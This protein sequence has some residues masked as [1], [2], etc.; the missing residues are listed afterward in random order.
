MP[1][2][3]IAGRAMLTGELSRIGLKHDWWESWQGVE[4]VASE[5]GQFEFHSLKTSA[6][7]H[8][9]YAKQSPHPLALL[10]I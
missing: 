5:F 9:F 2:L 8:A 10:L 4:I 7:R 3:T 6:A 1:L